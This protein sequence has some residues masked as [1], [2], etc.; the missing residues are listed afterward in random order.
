MAET[1][2]DSALAYSDKFKWSMADQIFYKAISI[3]PFNSRYIA[4]YA[5][6]LLRWGR[7]KDN[8]E[9]LFLKAEVL[10]G[11]AIALNPDNAE[12]YGNMGMIKLERSLLLKPKPN[13]PKIAE[14]MKNFRKAFENDPNGFNVNYSIGYAG[15]SAWKYLDEKDGEFI[16]DRLKY[17]LKCK[18]RYVQYVYPKLWKY[19]KDFTL[20]QRITPDTL[21]AQ[22]LLYD[23][24]FANNLWQFRK[25]QA[26]AVL[27]CRRKEDAERAAQESSAKK[28]KIGK[29]KYLTGHK[30]ERHIFPS[31]WQGTASGGKDIYENGNMYWSGT[32]YAI[33]D[34][35]TGNSI[36]TIRAKGEP[37]GGIWPYMIIELD[38]KLIGETFVNS[39]DWKEYTFNTNTSDSGIK[40]LSV[41]FMN[42]YCT[43]I[44]D[45]NLYIGEVRVE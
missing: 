15:I 42:D 27:N 34:I 44:E 25:T 33:I 41:T 6:F 30:A 23:F 40:V 9:T 28:R 35:P 19:T 29:I 13:M 3:N 2:F 22:K 7:Y 12:Y 31:D 4:V 37:E 17:T 18:I 24:I 5:D 32:V 36:I 45:R 1:Y 16:L 43:E 14:A 38:G 10:Y 26:E 11:R 21:Q 39:P 8:K 20:L